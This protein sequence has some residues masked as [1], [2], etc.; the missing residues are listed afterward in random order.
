MRK[1]HTI[2]PHRGANYFVAP[3]IERHEFLSQFYKDCQGAFVLFDRFVAE[4]EMRVETGYR[5]VLDSVEELRPISK[6]A[7]IAYM[8][9]VPTALRVI[10]S[11]RLAA[12][13][14]RGR[15][16]RNDSAV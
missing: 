14:H 3:G 9:R 7:D 12:I 1:L 10:I 16:E 13:L 6:L 5:V 4:D 8:L 2:I 15:G 11:S